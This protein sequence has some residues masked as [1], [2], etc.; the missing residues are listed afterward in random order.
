LKPRWNAQQQSN[1]AQIEMA[2]F[3]GRR[4]AKFEPVAGFDRLLKHNLPL[5]NR[6][7][8]CIWAG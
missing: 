4:F 6:A 3:N 8:A 2:E 7:S 5:V 1:V